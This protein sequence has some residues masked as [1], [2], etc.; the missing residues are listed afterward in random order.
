MLA[1]FENYLCI[2]EEFYCVYKTL[3]FKKKNGT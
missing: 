1:D 3:L 2:N